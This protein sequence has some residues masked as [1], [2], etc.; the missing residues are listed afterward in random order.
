MKGGKIKI[1]KKKWNGELT[2]EII[3]QRSVV[4]VLPMCNISS[5]EEG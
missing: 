3:F 1:K 4:W 2:R 5:A